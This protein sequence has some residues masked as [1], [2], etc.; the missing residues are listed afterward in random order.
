[1]KLLRKLLAAA[2]SCAL[3]LVCA[4]CSQQAEQAGADVSLDPAALADSLASGLTFQD[5]LTP[6]DGDAAMNIYGLDNTSVVQLKVYVSTGATAEEIAVIETAGG[7]AA[8]TVKA[9]LEKRVED[10]KLAFESYQPKEMTKLGDPL[11]ETRGKYVILCLSDDNEAAR[12][13][14]DEAAGA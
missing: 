10:Q 1:M 6:L 2:L 7:D 13:L 4:A 8:E 12:A 3:V 11:I 14:I 9:A 5:Q